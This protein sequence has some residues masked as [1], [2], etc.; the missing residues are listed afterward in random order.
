[1]TRFRETLMFGII[2]IIIWLTAL[3]FVSQSGCLTALFHTK[4]LPVY[5]VVIFG[6]ISAGIVIYRVLT[7]NDCPEANQELQKQIE[8]AKADLR[9]KRFI[10]PNSAETTHKKAD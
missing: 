2:A 6:L 10:F 9:S 5:T 7:F 3:F 4:L 1:M 8:Q